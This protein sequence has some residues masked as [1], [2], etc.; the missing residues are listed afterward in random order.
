MGAMLNPQPILRRRV[1][2][3]HRHHQ[4]V[5]QALVALVL[6]VMLGEPD[7]VVPALVHHA[8]E[9]FRL[10]EDGGQL[11]VREA[12]LVGRSRQLA[13]VGQVHVAGIDRRELRDH[14]RSFAEGA[15]PGR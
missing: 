2:C 10:L 3:V 12:P 8:G 13:H 9:A 15:A 6:E 11:L 4:D 14:G 7:R 1:T 5:G